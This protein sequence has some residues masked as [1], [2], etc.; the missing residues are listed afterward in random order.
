MNTTFEKLKPDQQ[1]VALALLELEKVKTQW[2]SGYY[3]A[4][5]KDGTPFQG[6]GQFNLGSC[7]LETIDTYEFVSKKGTY[8]IVSKNNMRWI[9]TPNPP[10]EKD[11]LV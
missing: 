6:K 11:H 2:I 1:R 5:S 7:I 10:V 4:V 8:Y 3:N 9:P